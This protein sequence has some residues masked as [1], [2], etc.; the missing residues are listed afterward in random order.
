MSEAA[1][2]TEKP[3]AIGRLA[4]GSIGHHANGWW[5]MIMLIITEAFLFFYLLFS[6]Y[7]FA[8]H[9]D[10]SF[11]PSEMPS[12]KFS[13]P[14]TGVVIAASLAVWFGERG[15]RKG[16]RLQLVG[17]LLVGLLLGCG[18]V[19]LEAFEWLDK[20]YTLASHTFGSEF[21]TI[22]GFHLAHLVGGLLMLLPLTLWSALGYFDRERI[23][24]VT[25]VM[26]YWFFI[27]VVWLMVF[28][29]LYV[30]PYFR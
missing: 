12:F 26:M 7:Y 21:F 24:P 18:F 19:V 13:G 3:L 30:T 28:F 10:G 23:V 29:T 2:E 20:S 8:S 27:D 16:S 11:F 17:G 15:G 9:A 22:T 25:I 6:Y 1:I 14:E 4:V 5:G